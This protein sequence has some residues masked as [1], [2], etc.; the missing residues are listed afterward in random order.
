MAFINYDIHNWCSLCSIKF[1]KS[2][3]IKCPVCGLRARIS[4]R[5]PAKSGVDLRM[6]VPN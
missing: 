3:G 4:A 1:H 5:N 6:R 2:K